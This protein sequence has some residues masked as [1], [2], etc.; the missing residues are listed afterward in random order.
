MMS[1]DHHDSTMG[2]PS[3]QPLVHDL[4]TFLVQ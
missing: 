4:V 2:Q 3:V 1:Y